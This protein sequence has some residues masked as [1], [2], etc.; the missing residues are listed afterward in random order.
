MALWTEVTFEEK[1]GLTTLYGPYVLLG[2]LISFWVWWRWRWRWDVIWGRVGRKE[3]W[4]RRML[5]GH[6]LTF[7][8]WLHDDGYVLPP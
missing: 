7:L 8:S 1:L 3:G 4:S 6:M 2:E 5:R